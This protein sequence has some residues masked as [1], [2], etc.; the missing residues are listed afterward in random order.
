VRLLRY[1]SS[2]LGWV[3]DLLRAKRC[4]LNELCILMKRLAR[5]AVLSVEFESV[6][7]QRIG[8]CL[9]RRGRGLSDAIVKLFCERR[10]FLIFWKVKWV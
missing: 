5:E 2:S 1:E 4:S 3:S 8:L 10:W 6:L 7:V 9:G